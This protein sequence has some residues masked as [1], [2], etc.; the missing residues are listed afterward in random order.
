MSDL[1][2]KLKMQHQ[3]IAVLLEEVKKLG[4]NDPQGL[5]KLKAAKAGLLAHF[6]LEEAKLYPVLFKAAETNVGLKHTLAM[7]AKDM[8][9]ASKEVMTFFEQ[10]DKSGDAIQLATS[11]GNVLS[12]LKTRIRREEETLYKEF[13]QLAAAA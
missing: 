9:G 12:L 7:L 3:E 11:F 4:V 10:C 2:I 5:S 6:K 13:D 1:T 8:E